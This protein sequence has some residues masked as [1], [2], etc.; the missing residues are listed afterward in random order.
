M[1]LGCAVQ[2]DGGQSKVCHFG[3]KDVFLTE[4]VTSED[5]YKLIW[6]HFFLR[7]L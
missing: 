7:L 4:Q 1:M 2:S 3:A 6:S 5:S